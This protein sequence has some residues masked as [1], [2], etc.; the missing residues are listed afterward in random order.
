MAGVSL[1]VTM[2][3]AERQPSHLD[4][5]VED[6]YSVIVPLTPRRVHVVSRPEPILLDPGDALVF[7]AGKLCHG[8]DGLALGEDVR[9]ALFCSVGTG[10]TEEVITQSFECEWGSLVQWA[11]SLPMAGLVAALQK[12][13]NEKVEEVIAELHSRLLTGDAAQRPE[14][15]ARDAMTVLRSLVRVARRVAS[16]PVLDTA[17]A[18]RWPPA[19]PTMLYGARLAVAVA[20]TLDRGTTGVEELMHDI[21]HAL[22]PALRPMTAGALY[23]PLAEDGSRKLKV[24]PARTPICDA[25]AEL[26]EWGRLH[27]PG[28]ATEVDGPLAHLVGYYLWALSDVP[29]DAEYAQ[30]RET[31][32]RRIWGMRDDLQEACVRETAPRVV[33]EGREFPMLWQLADSP[34]VRSIERRLAAAYRPGG[35][36]REEAGRTLLSEFMLISTRLVSIGW[37]RI[38]AAATAATATTTTTTTR[39]RG[40]WGRPSA[41]SSRRRGTERSSAWPPSDRPATRRGRAPVVRRR[42]RPDGRT[43]RWRRWW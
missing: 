13:K 10:V 12:L 17:A 4:A 19:A 18:G 3:G 27:M 25:I 16:R 5:D 20:D 8:G 24:R 43:R 36:E 1:I 30:L 7:N 37:S 21:M 11:R 23:T 38:R 14:L 6:V 42:A 39:R 22:A 41:W 9:V 35:M 15:G 34:E 29:A 40:A 31:A 32:L 2:P 28:L 26:L 33:V